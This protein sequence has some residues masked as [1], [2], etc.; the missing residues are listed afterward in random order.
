MAVGAAAEFEQKMDHFGAVSGAT[1][2]EL[3]AVSDQAMEMGRT[4]V[5]SAIEAAGAMVELGKAGFTAKEILEG[6]GEAVVALAAA[7]DLPLTEATEVLANTLRTFNLEA[8]DAVY[9]ANQLAGAANASTTEVR[10]LA[11]SLRYVGGVASALGI[12][13][14]EVSD[15]LAILG[16]NG[17]KGSTAGTTLR[18]ILLELN[19]AT[20]RQTEALMELGIIQES[21]NVSTEQLAIS[22]DKFVTAQNAVSKAQERVNALTKQYADSGAPATAQEAAKRTQELAAANEDLAD[23]QDIAN[24]AAEAHKNTQKGLTNEFFNS[25]GQA[26]SLGEIF[27][28]VEDRTKHLNQAEKQR[29]LDI[30]FGSRAIA[31][32]IILAREGAEGFAEISAQIEKVSAADVAA[33]RLDNLA[34][35]LRRLKNILVTE[36]VEAASPLLGVLKSIVDGVTSLVTSFGGLPAPVRSAVLV[37]LLLFGTLAILGGGLL[38]LVSF[39]ARAVRAFG[40][41]RGVF[42]ATNA[43]K[44]PLEKNVPVLGGRLGALSKVAALVVAPFKVIAGIFALIPTLVGAFISIFA[45][46]IALFTVFYGILRLTGHSLGDVANFFKKLGSSILEAFHD[47]SETVGRVISSVMGWINTLKLGV[48]AFF[49]ALS[50]EGVT[51]DGFVGFME[52]IAVAIRGVIEWFRLLPG[53]IVEFL[54]MALTAVGN[55]VTGVVNFFVGLPGVLI[56]FLGQVLAAF[57]NFL[58]ELPNRLAY[59]VG[60]MIGLW[61]RL[62]VEFYAHMI[63]WTL[64]LAAGIGAFFVGM[65]NLAI[66]WVPKII[67][68]IIDFFQQLPGRVIGFLDATWDGFYA[69]AARMLATAIEVGTNVLTTVT[70]WFQ[71]LPGRVAEFL[72]QAYTNTV[73]WADQTWDR[74]YQLGS[75]F[76]AAIVEWFSQLPGRVAEFLGNV[77][78]EISTWVSTT[79]GDARRMGTDFYNGVINGI[80]G[81]PGA[82]GG[83]LG[84]VIDA[85]L[86]L[87]RRGYE[88]AKS[89]ASSLWNGFKAGLG[90]S[91]PSFIERA[92]WAMTDNVGDSIEDLRKQVRTIQALAMDLATPT[93]ANYNSPAAWQALQNQVMKLVQRGSEIGTEAQTVFNNEFHTNADPEQISSQIM[94]DQLVRVR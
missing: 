81:L 34:G 85:F 80:Q 51:S 15:A 40:E 82:I 87:I 76:L 12:P 53:R 7:G 19:P 83:I 5:F 73:Q 29:T 65:F 63:Q 24:R 8:K 52:R 23:K 39:I 93:S 47:V 26:K 68:A 43:A 66:E 33:Q 4:T 35:S 48:K 60:Y 50:G 31:G 38:L 74:A 72:A 20:K 58:I 25:N 37:A 86:G 30:I 32:A 11:V 21:A 46:F 56:G 59:A 17:I 94:W 67:G 75:D 14:H 41:L 22:S 13:L 84:R 3:K 62:W 27:Q 42:R 89:L 91:S 10:D 6:I 18:R 44:I 36:M 49:A 28:I 2:D 45:P 57:G 90:I 9:V 54:S 1:A 79:V 92:T 78:Q 64:Q 69:W 16:N 61:I 77:V 88:A 71:Q 70:E 55:F